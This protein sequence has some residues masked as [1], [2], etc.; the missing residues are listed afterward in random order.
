MKRFVLA[1]LAGAALLLPA[2]ALAKEPSEAS[3]NGPG[4][5]KTLKMN[6][7]FSE[8]SPLGRLTMES[9]FFPAAVGQQPD[10]M[11]PG[12][13]SVKLGPKYTIV[14]TVPMG[15]NTH[16]IRQDLYPYAAG[17]AVTHMSRGQAIFDTQTVGGW[18]RAYGLKQT[19]VSLGLPAQAA[20]RGSSHAS[21]ALIGIPS[22]L[23]LAG[24]AIALRRRRAS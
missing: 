24:I 21:L 19:L 20:A 12:R 14:W 17:G 7:V 6:Q 9:G 18:Y 5:S 3:I 8:Q 1:A 10:P 11:L 15:G 13:P 4:F 23:A 22:V 2:A 16:R